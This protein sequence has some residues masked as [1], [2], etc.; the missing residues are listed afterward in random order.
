MNYCTHCGGPLLLEVPAGD[1]R[2]RYCCRACGLIHY[3]NPKMVVGC[4]PEWEDQILLCL[5]AIEPRANLW[6]LP[7][8]FLENN[9]TVSEGARREVQEET[10]ARVHD[11]Q[12]Y[13]LYNIPHISQI[14]FFF[15]AR[16]KN[17][18]FEPTHES[19]EVRLFS[20]EEVPWAQLAFPVVEKT[21]KRYF[22]DRHQQS[23]PFHI[24]IITRSI[25]SPK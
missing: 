22:Q 13:G 3:Q 21:L 19:R 25:H 17:N 14:Y 4:I 6:T 9:E 8:G 20:E 11:L 12:P 5:R 18:S 2:P 15:R 16:L 24:D 1:D 10:H 7:A 23:F